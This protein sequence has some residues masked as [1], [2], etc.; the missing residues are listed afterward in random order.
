MTNL[1][2]PTQTS[3]MTAAEALRLLDNKAAAEK[4]DNPISETSGPISSNTMVS[5]A[6]DEQQLQNLLQTDLQNLVLKVLKIDA[7]DFSATRALMD[8]GL[9]SIAS[10]EI[11][12]LFTEAFKITLPPTIFFEFQDLESFVGYLMVNHH[13]EIA[14]KYADNL[15]LQTTPQPAQVHNAAP[16][17]IAATITT[18][19]TSPVEKVASVPELQSVE[20]LW[21]SAETTAETAATHISTS[22][23][24]TTSTTAPKDTVSETISQPN[25]VQPSELLSIE[26][27]WARFEVKSVPAAS[28]MTP[29]VSN[30]PDDQAGPTAELLQQMQ[31]FT[32]QANRICLQRPNRKPLEFAVYGEGEPVLLLGGLVMQYDVMWRLQLQ[33]LGKKHRLIMFHMP[34]CEQSEFYPEMSLASI[35]ED[36]KDL[37]DTLAI[38]SLPII[39][40]SFGGILAQSFS[41]TYPERCSALC[42][43][44]SSATSEGATDFQILMREL[45]KSSLFM[46]LNRHWKIPSLPTYQGVISGCDFTPKLPSINVPTLVI[47]GSEDSYQTPQQGQKIAAL[48]PG[49]K[50]KQFNGAGHLLGFTHYAE[51]NKTLLDFLAQAA[52]QQPT[53]KE[54]NINTHEAS[55][56]VFKPT[57]SHS[58]DVVKEY[59]HNGEQGHCAILSTQSAKTAYL[60]NRICNQQAQ[61]QYRS[62]FMTSLE[63]SLDAALRLARHHARNKAP[64][65]AGTILMLDPSGYWQNYFDPLNKGSKN[66]LVPGIEFMSSMNAVDNYIA[67]RD[68]KDIAAVATIPA[69]LSATEQL[70]G[71]L[72]EQ[73]ITSVLIEANELSS[74]LIPSLQGQADLIVLGECI[75][76]FQAPLGA[77]MIHSSMKNPWLMTPNE[78]YV[79]HVMTSFGLTLKLAFEYLSNQFSSSISGQDHQYLRRVDA[80]PDANYQAHLEYANVGYAK[81]ARL[82]GFDARFYEARGVKSRLSLDGSQ[83]REIIDCFVNV[84]TCPRGLN[85]QDISTQ[86]IAKHQPQQD[87]W[88]QLAQHLQTQ[89]GFTNTLPASSNITAVEAAITLGLM[90]KPKQN[91]LLCFTGGLGF[92]MVS[93]ASSCDKVF[94]IF[95]QP[96]LPLFNNTLFIDPIAEDAEQALESA[97]TSGE[98]GMVWFETIQVDANASRPIPDNLTKLINQHQATAGYL[99]GVD[100]TQTNLVTGS[101]LHSHAKVPNPDIVALGTALCDSLLPM[102]AVLYNAAVEGA[103][104]QTNPRRLADLKGRNQSPLASHIALNSLQDIEQQ[105]LMISAKNSGT[106]FKNAL[107][108]LQQEFPLISEIRGEGLLLTLEMDLKGQN[109][110]VERSFGYLLWG[111]MLRDKEQG[112]AVAVCPIHNNCIRFLPPLTIT[113]DEIDSIINNLRRTL[114]LG[115]DGVLQNCSE[116]SRERGDIQTSDFLAGLVKK[117]IQRSKPMNTQA[118]NT[119]MEATHK[120]ETATIRPLNGAPHQ[121][122]ICIVG[123][124]VGGLSTAKALE[125]KGIAYDCFD[126]RDNLGGI[127]HFDETGKHTSVWYNLNQNTPRSLYQFKD[128]PMPAHYPDFPSHQQVL[129]YLENYA[130]HFNLLP[131]IHLNCSVDKTKR[132]ENGTWEVTLG[133]GEV[134]YYDGLVV[135]NGHHN[136]PNYPDYVARDEFAGDFI[137]SK[138]YRYRHGYKGKKVLVVGVGNSG[139]QI[140]VDVSHDADMTFLSLRR[141]VYVLPHYM[142]GIR[143]DK[144]MGCLND[145]WVKKA[146][147]YPLHGLLF[148]GMY[149]LLIA[150]RKQMG[151]PKPDHLMMSSLPTLS[152]N[153]ANRI[154]DGKLKIVPE[155]V[156]IDG[157]TVHLSDGTSI[158]VDSIVYSTGYQT[159]FP[160]LDQDILNVKDNRVPLYQRIF[161]PEVNNI[162]FIGLFQAV[163]WGFLDMMERQAEVVADYFAG[164]YSL[165]SQEEQQQSIDQDQKVVKKE[166]LATLRN[167]Y[168][169]HGPTYM[170]ELKKELKKGRKRAEAAGCRKP[171]EAQAHLTDN[172][173]ENLAVNV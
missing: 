172:N 118:P 105:G 24:P 146:L 101:L 46:A 170:H 10:T 71:T 41:L 38:T 138:Q 44:V 141:G 153:F 84:G 122:R 119:N 139:S 60:L 57:S 162:A 6:T 159:D 62:Y 43:T 112:V 8:Y 114:S 155:V 132:L 13:S 37:L 81:V 92:T 55:P 73:Q 42:L 51:Y 137:H 36:I 23:E 131:N 90:A 49:A 34:G 161:K 68:A 75:T 136:T 5:E 1:F 152:E 35:T 25:Q 4:L 164:N 66:A 121:P 70:L 22:P 154:G 124:G 157:H 83:S 52:P 85:P 129:K 56:S 158:E 30:L 64:G 123:A 108:Q 93:A 15:T 61:G 160:F 168:E 149:K 82:H 47:S 104:K 115:I 126:R 20:A 147:P 110:F 167:N 50:F 89:T 12:N 127:W 29:N 116:Y 3:G 99:I 97:L 18:A 173:S 113:Q 145:W 14:A 133:N 125:Q 77:C 91:K 65:G 48:I 39:G 150:K 74:S 134:R 72:R 63:E 76:D 120:A 69:D 135:A 45:Q 40:Y 111:A 130:K 86:V 142:F 88:Q 79:R 19:P 165:P 32:D 17:P 169:M 27:M 59:V 11:G 106:Y 98:I 117:K 31:Q 95:R 87:Y 26:Q 16:A 9:D 96:F 53:K 67:T 163:T 58:L 171:F 28:L 109:A 2:D 94:D 54:S 143:M 156:S 7:A 78:S 144:V 151:M 140:A 80:S 103:A 128:F 100:E 166:F 102:G 148:T 107:N 21:Q 33:E